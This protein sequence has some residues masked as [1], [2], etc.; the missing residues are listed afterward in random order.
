[1]SRWKNFEHP[2]HPKKIFDFFFKLGKRESFVS[3]GVHLLAKWRGE[4]ERKNKSYSGVD[5]SL[6]RFFCEW[7]DPGTVFLHSPFPL[8]VCLST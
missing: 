7:M 1:M 2:N 6:L 5:F 8:F 3:I 4:L